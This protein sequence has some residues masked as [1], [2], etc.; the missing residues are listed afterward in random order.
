MNLNLNLKISQSNEY[1]VEE[2]EGEWLLFKP[3]SQKAIYLDETAS[4]IWQMCDESRDATELANE[5]ASHYP[6]SAETVK[7]DVISALELLYSHGAIKN[8]PVE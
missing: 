5:I 6:D 1:F 7:N 8:K 3:E 2:V 4:L